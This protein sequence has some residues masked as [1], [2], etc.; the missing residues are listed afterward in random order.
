MSRLLKLIF[1]FQLRIYRSLKLKSM[2]TQGLYK[3]FIKKMDGFEP[4][5]WGLFIV[6]GINPKPFHHLLKGLSVQTGIF[7]RPGD[8]AVVHG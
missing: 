1:V 5:L 2:I 6:F 8:I 7:G 3:N 4:S